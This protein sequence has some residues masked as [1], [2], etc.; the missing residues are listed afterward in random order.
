[1]PH[2]TEH[3]HVATSV[4]HRTT[5]DIWTLTSNYHLYSTPPGVRTRVPSMSFEF[6]FQP[7]NNFH[8]QHLLHEP[9]KQTIGFPRAED[10]F[11]ASLSTTLQNQYDDRSRFATCKNYQH[12]LT[13]Y[14]R[15]HAR[16]YSRFPEIWLSDLKEPL[17]PRR[18]QSALIVG[19]AF[20]PSAWRSAIA[21]RHTSKSSLSQ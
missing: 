8:V 21:K 9:H 15:L 7:A 11:S 19:M 10:G 18:R 3:S 1:V 12:L 17:V 14:P 2:L 6:D 13:R 16:E 20:V 4:T 5:P